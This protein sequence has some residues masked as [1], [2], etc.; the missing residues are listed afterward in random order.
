MKFLS[1]L[2]G[3]LIVGQAYAANGF[4]YLNNVNDVFGAPN[5]IQFK[6]TAKRSD[7]TPIK[8]IETENMTPKQVLSYQLAD[9]G[10][11]SGYLDIYV[12]DLQKSSEYNLC[13]NSYPYESSVMIIARGWSESKNATCAL[14]EDMIKK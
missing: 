10:V 5:K 14:A 8:S 2:V 4:L 7:K 9:F 6:I 3:C 1:I 13:V 11:R 12:R